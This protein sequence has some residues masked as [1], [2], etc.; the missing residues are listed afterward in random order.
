MN[1]A[2]LQSSHIH[3]L[4]MSWGHGGSI[5][6][7]DL[8][9]VLPCSFFLFRPCKS[10]CSRMISFDFTGVVWTKEVKEIVGLLISRSTTQ[11]FYSSLSNFLATMSSSLCQCSDSTSRD[12]PKETHKGTTVQ[13]M[14]TEWQM[15]TLTLRKCQP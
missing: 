11:I 13:I 15:F 8:P 2:C 9:F 12:N 5:Q 14:M 4:P 6:Y 10:H 7:S 3:L 1:H